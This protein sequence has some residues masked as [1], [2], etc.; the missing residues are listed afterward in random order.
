MLIS[1]LTFVA[2]DHLKYGALDHVPVA[3]RDLERAAKK[4]RDWGFVLKKGR[5]HTNS[6]EN[7]HIKFRDGTEIELITASKPLDRVSKQY[8]DFLEN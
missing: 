4:F 2:E 8:L 5:Q 7:Y 1:L 3:V 6:I